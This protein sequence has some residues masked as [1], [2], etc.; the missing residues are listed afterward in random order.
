MQGPPTH[1]SVAN[2]G[3]VRLFFN[4]SLATEES[5]RDFAQRCRVTDA[6]AMENTNLRGASPYPLAATRRW[7]Q[8][9]P[10]RGDKV[11]ATTIL[12]I[13][14]GIS[15][16]LVCNALGRRIPRLKFRRTQPAP[17]DKQEKVHTSPYTPSAELLPSGTGNT[18]NAPQSRAI[19]Y[20]SQPASP[21]SSTPQLLPEHSSVEHIN[22]HMDAVAQDEDAPNEKR[23]SARLSWREFNAGYRDAEPYKPTSSPQSAP[24]IVTGDH[25]VEQPGHTPQP[26]HALFLSRLAKGKSVKS[27]RSSV[28]NLPVLPA[29]ERLVDTGLT[30][31]MLGYGREPASVSHTGVDTHDYPIAFKSRDLAEALVAGPTLPAN[32]HQ[33]DHLAGLVAFSALLV[34]AI[35]FCLT[36]APAAINPGDFAHYDSE[37]WARKTIGSYFLNLIWIGRSSPTAAADHVPCEKLIRDWKPGPF[38]MTSAR[39]LVSRY[40]QTGELLGIAEKVVA[41]PFRLLIP[42]LAVAML[43]YFFMDSGATASLEYLASVTWCT[44]PFTTVPNNFGNFISEFLE[45]AYLIPNAVPQITFNYCTGVLWTIPIQL[46]GSWVT[47][48]ACIVI[49]EIKKPWKRF[50]FYTF[51]ILMQ[52]YA[53][54]WGT[55]FYLGILLTD[56]DL[57]YKYRKWL[58]AHP[59]VYYPF[60]ILCVLMA[61]GALSM[62]MATQ[63]T[64]VQYAAFEYGMHPDIP[65]GLPIMWT[66]AAGYPQYYIPTAHGIIFAFGIQA[67]VELSPLVQKIFSLNVFV[68]V[69]PHIYTIYLIHGF[70]FWSLGSLICVYLAGQGVAYWANLLIVAVCCY[71]VLIASCPL[72]TPVVETLGKHVTHNIWQFA[73]E[74]PAPRRPTL[75]PFPDNF[76]FMRQFEQ[77]VDA[78]ARPVEII[79]TSKLRGPLRRFMASVAA[80]ARPHL[81]EKPQEQS[82]NKISISPASRSASVAPRSIAS[83]NVGWRAG[84]L[85][86]SVEELRLNNSS[87][88]KDQ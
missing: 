3:W 51:C 74:N 60:I 7:K 32:Q 11:V 80:V 34:T 1:R 86:D 8:I 52:W 12:I 66:G 61:F 70:I 30:D 41:R 76:L 81:S 78:D 77:D 2:V 23:K 25:I 6:C 65:T 64:N 67:L 71:A 47:L 46:Q 59:F 62:D 40:L 45:L 29:P 73:H 26:T 33:V 53:L 82:D 42:I 22:I 21:A 72:L 49:R 57:T 69:F 58:Y 19:S 35:H 28:T 16:F 15:F 9:E 55:Y 56:L 48:L 10:P 50:G 87:G 18:H 85:S 5:R 63:W 38:L 44:W 31:K 20:C 24:K 84:P 36:F 13:C 83:R 17:E 75:Y 54:S 39:F 37:V 4:S 14:G 27:V 79:H 88:T 43:E 68:Y